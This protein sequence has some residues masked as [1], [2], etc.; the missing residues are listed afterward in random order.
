MVGLNCGSEGSVVASP[1]GVTSGG[2]TGAASGVGAN[3]KDVQARTE[4]ARAMLAV[5][6]GLGAGINGIRHGG[7]SF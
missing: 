3:S 7:G 4:K 1:S 2:V 6:A 5:I